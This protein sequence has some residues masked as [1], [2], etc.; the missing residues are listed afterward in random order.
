[1][2]EHMQNP[3]PPTDR[4]RLSPLKIAW[5]VCFAI[6]GMV[7]VCVLGVLL[8]P[9][10]LVN[11]F[12][13]P[14]IT[15]AFAEAYPAYSIRIADMQYSVAQN[16]FSVDSVAVSSADGTFSGTMGPF[17]VSGITWMHF[18]WRGSLNSGDFASSVLEAQDIVLNLLPSHYELRC[19][20]LSVSIPDSAMVAV[21]LA[22]HPLAGDEQFFGESKYR[23]TRFIVVAPQC[24]VMGLA[25][26]ELLQAKMY[27]ARS[28]H[29][30]DAFF[31]ILIDKD[32][33]NAKD[34]SRL[35]MP[36]EILSS[37]ETA[38]QVDSLSVMNGRLRYGERYV[39]G[40]TPTLITFDSVRVLAEGIANHGARGTAVVIHAQGTFMKGGT[41]IVLM[42][43]PVG[44]P[45]FSFQYSGSLS[46]MNLCALNSHLE[47]AE[48]MRITTG[49][50]Q[51]ATFEIN[52]TSGR[53][54]GSVRAVYRDLTIAA[55]N[56]HTGSETG[57]SDTIVSW[58]ANTFKIRSTNVPD[59]SAVIAI[60]KVKYMRN[61]DDPFFGFMWAALR[62]GVQDVV[63]W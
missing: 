62:S 54:S 57:F 42:S 48:Q 18:L 16:R 39:V 3:D 4:R 37:I 61:R 7:L 60:G 24:R 56:R 49:I 55:I 14:A 41:M 23:R 32:K 63:G 12:I 44:S 59:E 25:C 34:T 2:K 36:N 52:V 8:F 28:V 17:S 40:S 50:L 11:R 26:L 13:K 43:I 45:E 29:I 6:G 35:L 47:P 53:A 22:I 21:S 5:Y 1:M 31:D 38:V 33:P 46:G 20:R 51:A 19:K 10:P 15:K 30:R 9:N 58:I 27:R